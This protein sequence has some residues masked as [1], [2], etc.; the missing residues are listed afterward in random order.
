MPN[1]TTASRWLIIVNGEQMV[2]ELRKAPSD[3]LSFNEVTLDVGAV[4]LVTEP[5][6]V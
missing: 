6:R 5:N 2:D 3:M 4:L 1:L